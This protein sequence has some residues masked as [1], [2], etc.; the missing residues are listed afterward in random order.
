MTK[1]GRPKKIIVDRVYCAIYDVDC[2]IA[3]NISNKSY[4]KKKKTC[5]KQ[6]TVM[7][8]ICRGVW[9]KRNPINIVL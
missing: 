5:N 9:D 4:N 7:C 2:H 1:R 6:D 8:K 3:A